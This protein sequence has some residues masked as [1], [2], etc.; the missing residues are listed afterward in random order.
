MSMALT[1]L[2]LCSSIL[3][4]GKL[5]SGGIGEQ[6]F[7]VEKYGKLHVVIFDEAQRMTVT[8]CSADHPH[9]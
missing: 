6:N 3:Q 7:P 1:Y 2:S 4:E 8:V 5:I 9:L